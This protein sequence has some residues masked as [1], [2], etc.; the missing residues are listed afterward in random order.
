MKKKRKKKKY[1]LKRNLRRNTKSS[2]IRRM[3]N[4][5]HSLRKYT[6]SKKKS[7][8]KSH[9]KRG[10]SP[11]ADAFTQEQEAAASRQ[12]MED[13][14]FAR[15]KLRRRR[16]ERETHADTVYNA[17]KS[18]PEGLDALPIGNKKVFAKGLI[19]EKYVNMIPFLPGERGPK[20]T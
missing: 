5:K 1:I 15:E 12:L 14:E 6:K 10:G 17:N 7:L 8:K 20:S 18:G 3:T 11:P 9:S 19:F 13:L 2:I 4:K 16:Q